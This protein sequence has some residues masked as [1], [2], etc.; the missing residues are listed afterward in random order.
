MRIDLGDLGFDEGSHL[1][2]KRALRSLSPGAELE[3]TGTGRD[4]EL[5][6]ATWCRAQGHRVRAGSPAASGPA[7]GWVV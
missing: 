1:L 2:V 3:V 6:L 7:G 5:H 4:L